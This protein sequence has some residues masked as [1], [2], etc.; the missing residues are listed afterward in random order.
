MIDFTNEL[1]KLHACEEACEWVGGKS[2]EEAWETC[3]RGD[4]MLWL[5]VK[6]GI[7]R[8]K[9]VLAAC[10]CARL[11]LKY[12]S[13][14][15]TRPL[16]AIQI[17]EAWANGDASLEEVKRAAADA[18]TAADVAAVADASA[19]FADAASA[20]AASAA[21]A[22]AAAY[23]V[24]ASAYAVTDAASAASACAATASAIHAANAA[25]YTAYAVIHAAYAASAAYVAIDSC[26]TKKAVLK[27][28]A[29]I[30]RSKISVK[31]IERAMCSTNCDR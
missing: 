7:D 14:K 9:V 24:T 15:E 12:V 25:T 11:S 16:K 8:K 29:D 1:R 30:M 21:A 31:D 27:Q 17:A 4:W 10:E 6:A 5:A 28:C 26:A 3:E 22:S 19:S 23:A 2:L 20:A 13:E 18:Y